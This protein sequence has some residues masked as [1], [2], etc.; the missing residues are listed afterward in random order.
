M[1]IE[2][3]RAIDDVVKQ[4][5][6]FQKG[7]IKPIST[8]IPM[9][10]LHLMGGFTPSTIAGIVGLS[11][12]G[13]SYELERI[14]SNIE[15]NYGDNIV[16]I[17]CIWELSL[18]KIVVREMAKISGKNIREVL[19]KTPENEVSNLYKQVCDR[20]R[21]KNKFIQPL[22]L[23][24]EEF[25]NDI[26]EKIKLYPSTPIFVSIDN[27]QNCL[28]EK[29]TE[30]ESIDQI[31]QK[32]NFLIKEHP[33]IFFLIVNQ[34]NDN[35]F[36]RIDNP[37]RHPIIP[38]DIYSSS[39]YYKLCDT[40]V[41]KILPHRLGIEKF[42]VFNNHRYNYIDD[43]FKNVGAN[44][45]TFKGYGN[46]FFQ[47]LKSRDIGCDEYDVQDLFVEKLFSLPEPEEKIITELVD[48]KY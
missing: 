17:K 45:S 3:K 28:I 39:Y 8:G 42:M 43:K 38:K 19:S 37:K 44:T 47:F 26:K 34:Q 29:G 25:Y 13:K 21:R 7:L 31:L 11:G 1:L 48:F 24:A 20:Y 16:H 18:L 27:L 10:D 41:A 4:I 22:P 9:W 23:G 32:I 12:M 15:D 36:D 46:I 6:S 2:G 40:I 33:F 5:N 35:Y 14:L 30:K